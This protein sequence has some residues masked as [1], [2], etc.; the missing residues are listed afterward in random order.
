MKK[1]SKYDQEMP[2]SHASDKPTIPWGRATEHQK[3]QDIY[4][5]VQALHISY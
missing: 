4:G 1:V 3:T 5:E 2:Q